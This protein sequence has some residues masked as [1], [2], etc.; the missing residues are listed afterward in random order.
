[1]DAILSCYIRIH[2]VKNCIYFLNFHYDFFANNRAVIE[3]HHFSFPRLDLTFGDGSPYEK[4]IE[5]LGGLV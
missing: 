2:V 1:M 3:L 4:W 5:G